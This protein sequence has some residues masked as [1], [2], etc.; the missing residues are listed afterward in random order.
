MTKNIVLTGGGSAGHVTPNL[1]LIDALRDNDWQVNYIGSPQ[2]I[3]Q[4]MVTQKQVPFYGVRSGKLRRYFSWKTFVEPFNV[5]IGIWQSFFLLRKL[6]PSL[7]FSKGGFVAFPVVVGAWLNKIPLIAHE[8]DM[9]PGLANRISYPFVDQICIPSDATKKSFK[10]HEKL[11]VTGTPIRQAL[12]AGNRQKGLAYCGFNEDLPCILV[13]GGSLGAEKLNL[14]VRAA[15]DQLLTHYQIIHICGKGKVDEAYAKRPG[16]RQFEYVQQE[17]P[18][19]FAAASVVVS[20]SGANSLYE[21]LALAKPHVLIPLS[22]AASRGDQ[23]HNANHF[24]DKGISL[25]VE[26][27]ELNPEHLSQAINQAFEQQDDTIQRI[28]ALNFESATDKII[29]LIQSK[30]A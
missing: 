24:K 13:M 25:V 20:R 9:T 11:V 17:L 6:K 3:E 5:L 27:H 14:T 4:E 30:L 8:S 1:A 2:G 19:L 28:R 23:I 22:M 7:V 16:Y 26:D 10:H 29:Q 15:L 12:F 18:D 21:I